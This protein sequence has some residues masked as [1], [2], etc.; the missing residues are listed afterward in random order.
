M[1][2]R[3]RSRILADNC[4]LSGPRTLIS[5]KCLRAPRI[6]FLPLLIAFLLLGVSGISA[7]VSLK[8]DVLI[9]NEASLSHA[10]I[11]VMNREIVTGVAERPGRHVEFYS[12][13]L[14]AL[15]SL[16]SSDHPSLLEMKDWLAKKYGDELEVVVAV[17]PETINFVSNYKDTLFVDVPVVI[18]GSS[19]DQAGKP[20]FDSRFTGT[21]QTLE[22]ALRLFPN[23]RHV[24]VVAGSSAFDRVIMAATRKFLS[25]FQTKAEFSYLVDMEMKKLLEQLHN[26]P[27]NSMVFYT[28]FSQDSTGNRFLNATKALPMVTSAANAPVFGISDTYLGHGIVGGAMMNFQEQGKLTARIVSELLDG[29]RPGEIP[30]E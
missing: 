8:N 14:D 5:R 12:E 4:R 19:V 13:S 27:E 28:S 25:S 10:L 21:W 7:Q 15:N 16:N 24:F 2:E 18:C 22:A 6:P 23:T 29:K 3:V 30:I 26:L 11:N 17:G 20:N 9:L 1:Q